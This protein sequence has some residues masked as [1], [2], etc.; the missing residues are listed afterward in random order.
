MDMFVHSII[1]NI[2]V[3]DERLEEIRQ[4]QNTDSICSQVINF[5][6]MDYC[7]EAAL[8]DLKL[9]PYWFIRQDLTVYQGLLLYQSRLVTP[10]DLQ[11][12]IMN[13]I[14]EGHLGIVKCRAL[15]RENVWWPGLSKQIAEKVGICSVC[16]KERKYPPEPLLAS[17][18]PDYPWKKVGIDLFKLKGHT[19]LIII[20]YYSRWI[21]LSSLQKTTSGSIVNNCKSVFSRNGI[22]ELV[23][24]D[25]GPQF[26]SKE[27]LNFSNRFGFVH[28][29]S[30]PHYP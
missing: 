20:D 3:S 24:S 9:R 2:S 25:N 10:V 16:E 12:D 28:L 19:Y 23:I 8:R 22:P 21:E 30:S 27:F 4:K 15:A 1:R 13:R 6:K 14:H 29:T 11:N 5:Y 18:L 26:T 17:K 7:P